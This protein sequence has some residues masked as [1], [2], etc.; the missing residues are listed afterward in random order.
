MHDI[1]LTDI[2]VMQSPYYNLQ[3]NDYI[4][5]KPLKQKTWGTGKTGIES[6]G[7][8]MTLISLITTTILILKL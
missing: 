3:P 6:I 2:R 1:D 4:L 8:I 5:V 7:G